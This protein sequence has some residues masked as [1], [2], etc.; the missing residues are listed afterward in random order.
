MSYLD[1]LK[2]EAEDGRAVFHEFALSLADVKEDALFGFF[3]G[4]DDPAFYGGHIAV[5]LGGREFHPFICNGR[6]AVLKANEMVL[7]DGRAVDR[8]LFF[9]DKDHT[10]IMSGTANVLENNVFQ[11]DPYAIENYLVCDEVFRRFWTERLH[12]STLDERFSDYLNKFAKLRLEFNKRCRVLM[13]IVLFGRGI[14]GRKAVKLNLSNVQFD[15]VLKIDIDQGIVRFKKGA[16]K[17]FLASTGMQ[18]LG[19]PPRSAELRLIYRKHLLPL[20]PSTFIRGKYELWFFWKILS[21]ISRELSDRDKAKLSGA[22]RAT[23][24]LVL[25]LALCVESLSPLFSC[26]PSLGQFL[27]TRIPALK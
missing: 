1:E 2:D 3:E 25:G 12:L 6:S 5:R 21:A 18:N 23:P 15:K 22:R 19:S 13:S 8:T 24:V 7:A 9:V 26:P 17:H 20:S 10:E 11:T 16:G 14:D 27:D 4:E